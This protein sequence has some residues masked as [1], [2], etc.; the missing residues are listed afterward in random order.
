[1]HLNAF[2][3]TVNIQARICMLY[4]Y[5]LI[6]KWSILNNK[7]TK[8]KIIDEVFFYYPT[9]ILHQYSR[10][11]ISNFCIYLRTVHNQL[12]ILTFDCDI[13]FVNKK[14]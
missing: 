11:E 13:W 9:G 5:Q 7:K 8:R 4:K 1:M 10:Y 14:Y 2:T 12:K 6:W 3:R